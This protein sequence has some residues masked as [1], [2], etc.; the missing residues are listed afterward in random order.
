MNVTDLRYLLDEQSHPARMP[1]GLERMAGVRARVTAIRQRRIVIAGTLASIVL[2]VV[3]YALVSPPAPDRG[4]AT[5]RPDPAASP[6]YRVIDGFPEY[7]GGARI[8]ATANASTGLGIIQVT[9][10]AGDLGFALAQRCDVPAD[11]ELQ[12]GWSA[13]G[14]R[15]TET[16]CRGGAPFRPD[17]A[18][19]R[20]AGVRPGE[21]VKFTVEIILAQRIATAAA[22]GGADPTPVPVPGGTFAVAVM[23][24]VAF[25]SYPLPPRPAALAPLEQNPGLAADP[26]AGSDTGTV[27]DGVPDSPNRPVTIRLLV[28]PNA[29][30]EMVAQTPGLLLVYV[31]G[32]LQVRGEW[33]DYDQ[34]ATGAVLRPGEVANQV[35]TLRLV[36]EHMTGDWRMIV[37]G[38]PP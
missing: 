14:R 22:P 16:S 27:V 29:P 4:P 33:W 13:N 19:W 8:V 2:M 26:R 10:V 38:A 17:A 9:A 5:G 11:I 1:A 28:A 32:R 12:L 36:P 24:R 20:M 30:V 21:R 34:R 37:H 35:V 6:G 25:A 7:A 3:G 31:D 18:A 15:L 23:R